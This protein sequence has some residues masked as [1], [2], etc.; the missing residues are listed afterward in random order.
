MEIFIKFAYTGTISWDEVKD[1]HE[2]IQ[3]ADFLGLVNLK[4]EA[5]KIFAANLEPLKAIEAYHLSGIWNSNFLKEESFKI[6]LQHFESISSTDEFLQ[7][8]IESFK[9]LLSSNPFISCTDTLLKGILGWIMRDIE[10]RKM[11][12]MEILELIQFGLFAAD[13]K[14]IIRVTTQYG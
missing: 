7:L 5:I 10:M 2:L 9:D 13:L 1:L 3:D 6:I 11:C 12:L 8:N 4:E 14:M